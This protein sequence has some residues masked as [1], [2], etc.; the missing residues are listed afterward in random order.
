MSFLVYTNIQCTNAPSGGANSFLRSLFT[1]LERFGVRFTNNISSPHSL[2]FL[3][4][5][6]NP[7]ASKKQRLSFLSLEEV[8]SIFSS[9]TAPIIHRKVNFTASGPPYLRS[10]NSLNQTQGDLLQIEFSPYIAHS[11]FQSQYSSNRFHNQGFTGPSTVIYNGVSKAIFNRNTPRLSF[12]RFSGLN[13][14]PL[15]SDSQILKL[16]AVSWS[17]DAF[18]GFDILES[19]DK[20]LPLLPATRIYFLGRVPDTSSFRHIRTFKPRRQAGVARFLK[21]MHGFL[22]FARHE[23]CSNALIEA[24]SCQLPCIYIDSGSNKELIGSHGIQLNVNNPGSSFQHF[25]QQYSSLAPSSFQSDRFDIR[26]IAASYYELFS[27]YV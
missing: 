10:I 27:S 20:L 14:Y 8:R 6:T 21:H 9:T 22:A 7:S 19:L 17:Q 2:V 16:C 13:Q 15:W 24:I 23:T 3:N 26:S 18:K 4:A 11:I 12:S 5:L 25:R 1:E